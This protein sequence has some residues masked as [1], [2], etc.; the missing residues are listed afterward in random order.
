M[1]RDSWFWILLA[2]LL[3][4][5]LA[6]HL[7]AP[8]NLGADMRAKPARCPTLRV[9]LKPGLTRERPGTDGERFW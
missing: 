3:T 7:Q 9:L 6:Q 5:H 2:F 1:V 8:L 4:P